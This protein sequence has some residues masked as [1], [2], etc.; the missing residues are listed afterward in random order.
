MLL[1]QSCRFSAVKTHKG[2][3]KINTGL[4]KTGLLL[5]VVPISLLNEIQLILKQVPFLL[6]YYSLF[7]LHNKKRI[8]F[9]PFLMYTLYNITYFMT[10]LEMHIIINSQCKE[11][12]RERKRGMHNYIYLHDTSCRLCS[13]CLILTTLM[14][15]NT[16]F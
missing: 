14:Y 9:R 5:F 12:Q 6:R 16:A 4:I 11:K 2:K 8:L 1:A 10:V 7:L 13:V 3:R 15:G